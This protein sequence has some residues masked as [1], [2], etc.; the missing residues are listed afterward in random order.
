MEAKSIVVDGSYHLTY[1]RSDIILE[2]TNQNE[3]WTDFSK[4][5]NPNDKDMYI[6]IKK[7]N[8]NLITNGFISTLNQDYDDGELIKLN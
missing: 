5:I 7:T 3:S 8:N 4:R 6:V 2:Y 1:L